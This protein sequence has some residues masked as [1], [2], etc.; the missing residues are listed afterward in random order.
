[1]YRKT[2]II[3]SF[4]FLL[5]L[6]LSQ[7]CNCKKVVIIGAGVSGLSA[8]RVLFENGQSDVT[9]L[10]AT[11]RIGGRIFTT[12]FK[13]H[14]YERGAQ[15]IHGMG[16]N[17]VYKYLSEDA[18]LEIESQGRYSQANDSEFQYYSGRPLTPI[19]EDLIWNSSKLLDYIG[20]E[21]ASM[22]KSE[23]EMANLPL[24]SLTRKLWR[25]FFSRHYSKLG[26][27][28][29]VIG[30]IFTNEFGLLEV[31]VGGHLNIVNYL[32]LYQYEEYGA[33]DVKVLDGYMIL[34]KKLSKN[35]PKSAIKLNSKVQSIQWNKKNESGVAITYVNQFNKAEV[36]HADMVLVTV[37]IGCLKKY[38]KTLFDPNLSVKKQSAIQRIG[39]GATNKMLLFYENPF[40]GPGK[41]SEKYLLWD[42]YDELTATIPKD[43]FS[44]KSHWCRGV[45]KITSY[46]TNFLMMWITKKTSNRIRKTPESELKLTVTNLLRRFLNNP[47]LPGPDDIITTEWHRDTNFLGTYS[48]PTIGQMSSHQKKVREPLYVNDMPRVFFAGEALS[49]SRY[50]TVD[51]AFSTGKSEGE[52][53][54]KL[55]HG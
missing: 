15:W 38:H 13:G 42:S 46:K 3:Y 14:M 24:G 17:P 16:E 51:G 40:W 54:L 21:I 43:E 6:C 11:D 27:T 29:E 55:I 23:E 19:I 18:N 44:V 36:I 41:F 33:T 20:L 45:Y 30:P 9:I 47:K 53:I 7:H 22:G 50:G 35:I 39:F 34:P 5:T 12:E 32:A 26:L 4:L 37:S 52:R 1:M 48:Y 28:R 25:K 31:A 2:N 8:A 10:E 49:V